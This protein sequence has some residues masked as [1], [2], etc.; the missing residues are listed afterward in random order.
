MNM[1]AIGIPIKIVVG[2]LNFV[3]VLAYLCLAGRGHGATKELAQ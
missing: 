3:I 2:S 1:F